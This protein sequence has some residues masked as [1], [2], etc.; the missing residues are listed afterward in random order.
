MFA[1]NGH[2]ANQIRNYRNGTRPSNNASSVFRRRPNTFVRSEYPQFSKENVH[3]VARGLRCNHSVG[4]GK[5]R[6]C[7][8][9]SK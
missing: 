2:D 1:Q 5:L 4:L 7:G 6:V 9:A 8:K 3:T